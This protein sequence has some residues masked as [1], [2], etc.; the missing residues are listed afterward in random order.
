MREVP[1]GTETYSHCFPVFGCNRTLHD[2]RIF[3]Y[4]GLTDFCDECANCVVS[5][6]EPILKRLVTVPGSKGL[7]ANLRRGSNA[8][9]QNVSFVSV[10][11]ATRAR[12]S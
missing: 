11:G 1:F 2:F 8:F 7:I 3:L 4:D 10:L 9:L 5:Y 12:I 6:S